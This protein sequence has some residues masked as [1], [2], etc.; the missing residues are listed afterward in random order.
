VDSLT[1]E[2]CPSRGVSKRKKRATRR[3]K[4]G[5]KPIVEHVDR[6]KTAL[7][8]WLTDTKTRKK[9]EGREIV[10]LFEFEEKEPPS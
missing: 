2:L 6:L 7:F 5:G 4:K 8:T 3:D 9:P 10:S 1:K